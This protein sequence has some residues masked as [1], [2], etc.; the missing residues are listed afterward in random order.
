MR[1]TLFAILLLLP[2]G[3]FAAGYTPLTVSDKQ[4]WTSSELSSYV[5]KTVRMTDDWYICSNYNTSAYYISPRRIYSPTNQAY[6]L[7]AEYTSLLSLNNMGTV[8]LTGV[9][10]Y[11]RTGERLR[12]LVVRVN[13]TGSLNFVSGDFVGNSR[14]DILSR[15]DLEQADMRDKHTLLVCAA[16]LEY[17]LVENLGTGFGAD[18]YA[19]HQ[20]QKEKVC[21]GLALINADIYGLVEVERGQ[22]ALSEIASELTKLT[23]RQ[24]TYIDDG[25]HSSGSYTKSGYVYCTQAVKPYS[26]LRLNNGGVDYRKY[27]QC[28]EE[29]STGERFTF[30]IN[31]FKAKSGK[32]SGRNADQG[33]GQGSFNADRV[34]EAGSVLSECSYWSTYV[35]DEDVLIMGDLNAYA[36]E[37]PITVLIDGGMTDLHR[38]FHADSSYSY[39]YRS[40][41]G[42]LDHALCNST[43]LEQVTGMFAYHINSDEHDRY[44]YDKQ[45]DGTMFRYSDHDPVVVGLKLGST[46]QTTADLFVEQDDS[47]IAHHIIKNAQGGWLRIY[48]LEGT[49]VEHLPIT[50]NDFLLPADNLKSGLY[51]VHI[52]VDGKVLQRKVM[53]R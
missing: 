3:L 44:T 51:I 28:F 40:E 47:D 46:I 26:T 22:A 29:I 13:S 50:D 8:S 11:H 30:S 10:G 27:L 18:S 41:A 5:G 19:E 53:I 16:N 38:F 35:S 48:T 34:A 1:H 9:S 24:F 2:L 20:G 14:E 15:K 37:D 45:D 49:L 23:G 6:P 21:A 52:F 43:M 32:G 31:H 36:K 12:N 4:T 7:S 42:Y 39:T 33:D 17:Y 25:G